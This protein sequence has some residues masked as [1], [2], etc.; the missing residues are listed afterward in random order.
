MEDSIE[1]FVR[2]GK[3]TPYS[4]RIAK[5]QARILT[6]GPTASPAAPVSEETILGLE[7]EG[8]VEL[9]AD[10]LTQDRIAF[11]LKKGKPLIN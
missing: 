8:F 7:R 6:G 11:M 9:C 4:G 5:V 1:S 3:I 2:Q 10:K